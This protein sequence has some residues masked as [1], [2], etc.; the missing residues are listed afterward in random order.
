MTK[1]VLLY[2]GGSMP[3]TEEESAKVMQ[4]WGAWYTGMGEA[5]AD[6]GNPFSG[7]AR[8]V[9]PD[10]AVSEGSSTSVSGYTI[11]QAS[12]LDEATEMARGCPILQGGGSI[13]VFETF[14]MG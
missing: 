9:S 6:P 5:V 1:Y 8:S 14:E 3:E 2:S 10:G 7:A 13:S 11:L 4:A 12:S